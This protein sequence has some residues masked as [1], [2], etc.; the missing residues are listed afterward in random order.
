M[1][2]EIGY[3]SLVRAIYIKVNKGKVAKTVEVAPEI[4]VDLDQNGKLLGVE[5]LNPGKFIATRK[6]H[7]PLLQQIARKYHAP[8]LKQFPQMMENVIKV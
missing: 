7:T 2:L 3:D 5:M 4:F 1:K 8:E 6:K